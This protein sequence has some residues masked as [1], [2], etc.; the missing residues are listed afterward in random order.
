MGKKLKS[1]RSLRMICSTLA[2]ASLSLLGTQAAH[3]EVPVQ[4]TVISFAMSPNSVDIAT[5]NN[6]VSF[7]LVVTSPNGIASTQTVATLTNGNNSSVAVPLIRTDSPVNAILTTVEF[8]GSIAL[9]SNLLT[10][11]YSATASPVFSLTST[12]STGYPTPT[13]TASNSSTL[14]GA[15]NLLQVRSGGNLN[16][17]YATF[18]GP[19][20]NPLSGSS[21]TDPKFN[22]IATPIWK[23]GEKFNPADYYQLNVPSLS[24]K[25][26]SS[27]PGTC[28]S[29]GVGLTFIAL[30]SCNFTVYTD[31]SA[32]YSYR[33]D[34]ENVLITSARVKPSFV[35][36]SIPTQSSSNLPLVIAGPLING[37]F[38]MVFPVS[39]TPLVCFG[40]GTYVTVIS[41][42]TCTLKYS[43]PASTNFLASDILPLTFE[44]SRNPQSLSF[45]PPATADLSSRA[46]NLNGT[47]S[48][49]GAIEF[50][51][52]TPNN[53][54]VTGNSLSLLRVGQCQIKAS[55]AG[56]TKISPVEVLR[57]VTITDS[58]KSTGKLRC[59]KGKV[60]KLVNASICP[61]G[62]KKN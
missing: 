55:Q 42:G 6:I 20:F 18:S 14:I 2:I 25:V 46:I 5:V 30:G 9:P 4:P 49:G 31:Q 56:G 29:D 45:Q 39:T 47:A 22:N 8:K 40:S 41:G 11:V 58:K 61:K 21:V 1:L 7:D 36:G 10:G 19:T 34:D 13:L 16:F 12:G 3:S 59:T 32:D 15:P 23:V 62:F 35:V 33:H 57:E 51:S 43:T 54:S 52:E 26:K 44:I 27:T 48:G 37:P 17:N 50:R 38:G 60:L 28:A 24:L 53:C